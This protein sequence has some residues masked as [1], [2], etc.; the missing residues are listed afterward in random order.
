MSKNELHR[1]DFM[2]PAQ[3]AKMGDLPRTHENCKTYTGVQRPGKTAKDRNRIP[4]SD[5]A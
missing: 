3:K 1:K 5:A 2:T 4:V